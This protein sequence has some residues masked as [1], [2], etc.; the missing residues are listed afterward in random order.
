MFFGEKSP[1][2]QPGLGE[3]SEQIQLNE[4]IQ[5]RAVQDLSFNEMRWILKFLFKH[6]LMNEIDIF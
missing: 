5:H 2:W 3:I 4:K 6:R 1:I